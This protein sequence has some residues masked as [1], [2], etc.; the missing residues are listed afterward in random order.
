MFQTAI[1]ER[2][3]NPSFSLPFSNACREHLEEDN[4][5]PQAKFEE[6]GL[7]IK[8][9]VCTVGVWTLVGELL[10]TFLLSPGR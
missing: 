6:D 2:L 4:F 10:W 3:R 9:L 7:A 1:R 8:G 5:E